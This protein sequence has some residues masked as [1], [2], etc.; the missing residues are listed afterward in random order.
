MTFDELLNLCHIQH[1]ALE[2]AVFIISGIP[3]VCDEEKV[4]HDAMLEY[5]RITKGIES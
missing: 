5:D 1:K 2:T 3:V 4:I